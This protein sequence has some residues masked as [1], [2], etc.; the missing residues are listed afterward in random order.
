MAARRLQSFME[1]LKS[2]LLQAL[3]PRNLAFY[4]TS[5]IVLAVVS[6][7]FPYQNQVYLSIAAGF[8]VAILLI[9]SMVLTRGFALLDLV[10]AAGIGFLLVAL[11]KSD[12]PVRA[13]LENVRHFSLIL[14]VVLT[15]AYF[16]L[17]V[18]QGSRTG[19]HA[20]SVK[21]LSDFLSVCSATLSSEL[22]SCLH[23]VLLLESLGIAAFL[24]NQ[25]RLGFVMMMTTLVAQI[26]ATYV[27][28]ELRKRGF[29]IKTSLPWR[30][31]G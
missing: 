16:V 3:S 26:R 7:L 4:G 19:S 17:R 8:A 28:Y 25:V 29:T 13:V 1:Q 20:I 30:K 9:I 14:S 6:F 2:S 24:P 22:C 21:S 18:L 5:I 11:F 12:L 31:R 27:S 10:F 23:P 15:G